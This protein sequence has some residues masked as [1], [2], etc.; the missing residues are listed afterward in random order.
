MSTFDLDKL[1]AE[2][3]AG[4]KRKP[5]PFKFA[6]VTYQLPGELDT[7]ALRAAAELDPLT[8][9]IRLLGPAQ[10]EQLRAAPQVLDK[11]TLRNLMDGYY[12]Y[13]AGLEAGESSASSTR[14]KR[15]ARPS[16]RT[17]NAST[18]RRSTS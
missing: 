2:R 11:V 15:T 1:I 16:K 3:P 14:S 12:R 13:I 5:F 10:F 4:K 6:G 17:S 7:I 9:L 18:R 8:A